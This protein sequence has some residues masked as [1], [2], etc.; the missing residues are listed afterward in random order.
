MEETPH[1]TEPM[2]DGQCIVVLDGT[3][4]PRRCAFCNR[5][6]TGDPVKMSFD[7]GRSPGLIGAA[8]AETFNAVKGSSYTGPVTARFYL[9]NEHRTAAWYVW[10]GLFAVLLVAVVG[11]LYV[12]M[13]MRGDSRTVGLLLSGGI[14]IGMIVI[15]VGLA[16]GIVKLRSLIAKK[17]NDRLVWLEG[18]ED[19][20]LN[21]LKRYDPSRVS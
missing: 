11:A 14:G 17:F 8:V 18:S 21:G 3:T 5:V 13:T 19:A 2:R 15:M 20:F 10:Y 6:P 4:L 16:L 12:S 1:E 9:C 7:D